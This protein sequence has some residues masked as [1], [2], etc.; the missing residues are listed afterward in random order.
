M[1]IRF[2]YRVALAVAVLLLAVGAGFV[3]L[4]DPDEA[5]FARGS[6]EMLRSHDLVVPHFEG[7][8]RL[9]KPPLIHWIQSAIFS[10]LG[11]KEWT[12]RL[13]AI[14]ASLGSLLLLGRLARRSFGEEG[15]LWAVVILASMPLVIILGRS[16]TL[17]ALLALHVLAVVALDL[18]RKRDGKRPDYHG[19]VTGCLL[20]LAFLIKG[21]V[22]VVLPLLILLAGR[23]ASGGEILPRWRTAV[24]AL[25][26]WCLVVLPWGVFFV[27]RVGVDAVLSTLRVEVAERYFGG[28]THV[29]P[30][31]FYVPV[32]LVGFL[33]WAA[34]LIVA[35]G[36]V[37]A[38]YRD[39][40]T[41]T[42]RY[43]AAGLLAGLLFFSLGQGKLPS[44]ILPLAPLAA[45]LV[46]WE[47]GQELRRPGARI[48]GSSLLAAT[49]GAFAVAFGIAGATRLD[50]VPRLVSWIGCVLYGFATLA[51][52][53]AL[54]ARRTRRVYGIAAVAAGLF[55][56]VL[57]A[58]LLPHTA[59]ARTAAYLIEAVPRIRSA[60]TVIVVDM[61]V[62]SLTYY[63]DRIPEQV[64]MA[65]LDRRLESD[66]APLFV[67]D[68]VDLPQVT[69][70]AR[71]RLREVGRQGKYIVY[72]KI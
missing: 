35:I 4:L 31:W 37:I 65:H 46:A 60:Q 72:E 22:G 23:T 44:Y 43:A 5:R 33:P 9:A 55:L 64:D 15:A 59:R 40:A 49:L 66:D 29:E 41:R 68:E 1:S 19:L 28:T 48:L 47:L 58:V 51:T 11:A 42:A 39:P 32:I 50:G 12:A 8:P 20:G 53:P 7:R 62:P 21:P 6:V 18:G 26:G 67:F 71:N 17:D 2:G 36:R 16:G 70:F 52:V 3:P 57:L 34:P 38:G 54:L 45:L 24:Q 61:K 63:L 10:V 14:L 30:P 25:A 27:R 13:P 56:A 69:P